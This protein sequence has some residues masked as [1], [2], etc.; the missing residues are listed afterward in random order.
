MPMS[1][2]GMAQDIIN[3]VQAISS[4]YNAADVE[5]LKPFIEAFCEGIR[6]HIVANMEVETEVEVIGV[7]PGDATVIATGKDT[8]IL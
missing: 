1:K 5:A 7:E 8:S 2:E 3:E 4:K 6:K